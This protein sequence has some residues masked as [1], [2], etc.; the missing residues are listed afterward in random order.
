MATIIILLSAVD[1]LGYAIQAA[2]QS[3]GSYNN[4]VTPLL[5]SCMHA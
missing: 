3:C 1:I 2:M 5:V 4:Y